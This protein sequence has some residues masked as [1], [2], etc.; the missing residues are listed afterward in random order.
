[1]TV[2]DIFRAAKTRF[3]YTPDQVCWGKA[4]YWASL[5]ELQRAQCD[6]GTIEGDC[7]DFATWCVGQL[8]ANG[9]PGRYIVCQVETGEWHCVAESDGLIL[10]NRQSMVMHYFGLP[11]QWH[12]I[13]GHAAG[14]A[15]HTVIHQ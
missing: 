6:T 11:Y 9:L 4:E 3:H 7:D 10:D 8:R 1:M 5:S 14:E 12:S 2:D 13:S 15:W